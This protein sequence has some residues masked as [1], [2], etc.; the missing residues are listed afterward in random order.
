MVQGARGVPCLT[1]VTQV[2]PFR[3]FNGPVVRDWHPVLVLIVWVVIAIHFF[4]EFSLTAA[5]DCFIMTLLPS[6]R[7]GDDDSGAVPRPALPGGPIYLRHFFRYAFIG[8][9]IS[10][11]S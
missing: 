4:V 6:D 11:C 2:E 1:C 10:V 9:L 5:E 7:G 3:K 8:G